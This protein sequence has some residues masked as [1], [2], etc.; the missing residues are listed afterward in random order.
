MTLMNM[1]E[2][3]NSALDVEMGRDE[4]VL[5]FGEDVGL[6]GGVFRITK[7]LQDKYGAKR[8]FD[9][10]LAES[11]IVGF[12]IGLAL[13]GFRPIAEIQFMGFLW[14]AIDQ[15]SSHASRLRNRTMSRYNVPMVVRFPY[16]G[17]VRALEHHAESFESVLAHIPGLKV[18]IPSNPSDAKGLLSSAIRDDDPVVFMEPKRLYR[19]EKAEVK[20]GEFTV[21][22]GKAN[23]IR[24]GDDITLLGWGAMVPKISKAAELMG[25]KGIS[26]EV[27]DVRSI[28]PYDYKTVHGSVEKT[29][30]AV[31]VQEAPRSC[32]FASEIIARI[33]DTEIMHLKA[34]VKRVTGFDVPFPFFKMEEWAIPDIDRIVR[35]SREALTW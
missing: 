5:I 10:P 21:E 1:A 23:V 9:T 32:G 35:A 26:A 31:I 2:A 28:S 3:L 12:A 22:I 8:V 20:E 34:P 30:R 18:V 6:N 4:D 17:G 29:G 16:G 7:G 11:S 27:I 25:E 19:G 24:E 33:N 13:Y 14:P 15:L